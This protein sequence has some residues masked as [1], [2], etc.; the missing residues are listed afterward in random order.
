MALIDRRDLFRLSIREFDPDTMVGRVVQ[1]L[2]ADGFVG[3][4]TLFLHEDAR[5]GVL[6]FSTSFAQQL[7]SPQGLLI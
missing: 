3:R 2:Q 7:N 1:G 5:I 6:L 4:Q